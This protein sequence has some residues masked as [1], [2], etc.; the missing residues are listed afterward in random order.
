[1]NNIIIIAEQLANIIALVDF[2]MHIKNRY[3]KTLFK[4]LITISVF[5]CLY[6]FAVPAIIN[7]FLN[8]NL[9]KDIVSKN[10]NAELDYK[11]AKIKTHIKPIVSLKAD[12]ITLK[13]KETNLVVINTNNINSK[14]SLASLICKKINIKQ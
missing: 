10:T 1:M 9:I 14:I 2:K 11:N 7:G 13:E 5:E 3:I 4:V 6:L 12:E 8:G